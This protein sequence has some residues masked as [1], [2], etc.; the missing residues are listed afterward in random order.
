MNVNVKKY[1][2]VADYTLEFAKEVKS[3][4]QTQRFFPESLLHIRWFRWEFTS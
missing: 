2:N 4:E 1:F 3:E